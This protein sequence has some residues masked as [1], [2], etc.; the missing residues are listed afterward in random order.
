MSRIKLKIRS[1][2]VRSH[3]ALS[4]QFVALLIC[5]ITQAAEP[6]TAALRKPLTFASSFDQGTD[7]DFALG[8]PALWNA[9]AMDQRD[10]AAKGL[11]PGGE[12]TLEPRSGR[13][14]GALRF[15]KYTGPMAFYKAEKN[16]PMPDD[17]WEGTI[18]F[19]LSTDP[20]AELAD[21][22]CDPIQLTSKQWDDAA[23]FVEF[24][25]RAAGV[26]FRLGVYAD[27]DVWNPTL[28]KFE[29]IPPAERPL[30]AV[31][32]PPFAKGKWT[33]VA[34]VFTN[35][36]TN[37][38]NGVATL[39]LDGKK[40]GEIA[41]RTQTFTWDSKKADLMLGLNYVGLLDELAMFN[42][43]LSAD[44]ISELHGLPGGV[45]DLTPKKP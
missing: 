33:H 44:E 12:V 21:G 32:K 11:P 45:K 28:R 13:F 30:A 38:P 34:I 36:N 4:C 10:D 26:P 18:S 37:K 23:I 17:V 14:G 24:E 3:A 15:K 7:A 1:P 2:N 9:P 16:F 40:A 39:Y 41:G 8:E 31:E 5:T 27:K 29:D 20:Q 43:A 6:A 22:F 42:R 25:K 35:F 19:W